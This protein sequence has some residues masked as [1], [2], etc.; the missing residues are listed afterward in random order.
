MLLIAYAALV[1]QQ[2]VPPPA[3]PQQ[4]PDTVIQAEPARADSA[5]APADTTRRPPR[6]IPV[7]AELERSAFLD[8]SARELLHRAREARLHQDTTLISYDAIAYQRVSMGLALRKLVPERLAFRE[9]QAVRVQWHRDRGVYA[10]MLGHR[11]AVPVAGDDADTDDDIGQSIPIPYLP[12]Q[13]TLWIGAGMAE[14]EVND[15][16]PVNPLASGAEAYYRYAVGDSLTLQLPDGRVIRLRE[17]R[18]RPREPRWNLSVGSLWFDMDDAKLVRAVYRLS[19]PMD[20]WQVV[21]EQ[22]GEDDVPRAVKALLNPLRATVR[23]VT[24]EY[25]LEDGR[26]WLPRVQSVDV[27]A[28]VSFVR[29]PMTFEQSFRYNQVNGLVEVPEPDERIAA[30]DSLEAAAARDSAALRDSITPRDTLTPRAGI[31]IT[32]ASRDSMRAVRDS[33]RK[34]R[35][36][37]RERQCAASG[38]YVRTDSRMNGTVPV[39][40]SIPCDSVALANSDALPGSLYDDNEELFGDAQRERLV[41]EAL[42]LGAQAGWSPQLPVV[43]WGL[44]D[45]LMRYNRVEGISPAVRVDQQLG[46]GFALS[47]QARIGSADLEPNAELHVTRD[48][49]RRLL[50]AGVYRRLAAANDWGDPLAFGNS[51]SALF[52]GR[53]DGLYYRSWGAEL[54]GEASSLLDDGGGRLTWR[55]FAERHG[56]AE[57]ETNFSFARWVNGNDLPGN[58]VADELTILGFG[59]TYSR[60]FG[61]DPRGLRSFLLVRGEGGT[62][63]ASY[64]RGMADLT[65]MHPIAGRLDG[66]LTLSAG[67]SGGTLPVQRQY[68]LGGPWTVHALRPGTA[69]GNAFWLARGELAY[70]KIAARPMVF[71]DVGWAG[72][73]ESWKTPGTPLSAAGIGYTFLDGLVRAELSR[74]FRPDERVRFDVRVGAW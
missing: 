12:G 6:R 69:S 22:D 61:L 3:P 8:A 18:V 64:T 48:D 28:Q 63:D 55:L 11:R 19:T 34:E 68:Y 20:I 38:S 46:N 65:L 4:P 1:L 2:P 56:V 71:F 44:G 74:S 41:R 7:T 37:A 42:A 43:R 50:R 30:M 35:D 16:G 45:G 40:V 10:E 54:G 57:G 59:W 53:D 29:A 9:D 15:R 51:A 58:I 17:L 36:L 31:R 66:A 32:R 39:T 21:R 25:G 13:E 73:R 27:E 47:A 5:R 70:G 52:L 62:A 14:V 23:A 67:T 49:G 33:L 72:S 26:F 24:V 60:S